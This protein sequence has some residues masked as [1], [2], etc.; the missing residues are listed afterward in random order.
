M[1]KNELYWKKRRKKKEKG[2]KGGETRRGG[3]EEGGVDEVVVEGE[4]SLPG[5]PR[6]WSSW[7]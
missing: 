3:L 5:G 1:A 4:C 6:G 2:K 7:F